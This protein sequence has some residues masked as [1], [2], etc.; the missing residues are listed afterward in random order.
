MSQIKV[1]FI[2]DDGT[3]RVVDNAQTGQSLMEVGRSNSVAGILADCGGACAC[4]TCHVYI[5]PDWVD[6][7]GAADE[8]ETDMLD[9]TGEVQKDNSRLSCQI[10]LT[11]ALDGLKVTVAPLI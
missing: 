8:I 7:V 11:E 1:T 2:E 5:D 3:E 4:A 10:F 6:A 9:M